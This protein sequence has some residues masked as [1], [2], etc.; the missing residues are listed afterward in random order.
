MTRLGM[1]G[2]RPR[3]PGFAARHPLP[4]PPTPLL[5]RE[6]ELIEV[7]VR[8]LRQDVRLLTLTGAGG[9]GKTRLAVE[10]ARML[11][12]RFIDGVF[13]VDLS[14][15]S[16]PAQV[17]PA[18][19]GVLGIRE[20][21]GQS[22]FDRLQ[23]VLAARE[24]L[25]LLDNFEH[26]L[27]AAPQIVEFVAAC[28]GLKILATSRAALRVRWEHEFVVWPL[29]V[30]EA[31]HA[32]DL[33]A[34]ARVPSVA[35][36]VERARA[37][38]PGLQLGRDNAP[39]IAEICQRLDGL[40]LALELAAARTRVLPPQALARRLDARLP[41]LS[42]GPRDVPARQQTL[43]ASIGW[44]YEL[45]NTPERRLFRRLAVFVG[46]G[47][48]DQVEQVC[49]DPGASDADVL[50]GLAGLLEHS[51]I[52]RETMP[53]GVARLRM[54]ETIR[55]FALD[56]LAASGEAED[57]RRRHALACVALAEAAD[58]DLFGARRMVFV[59]GLAAD[60]D[61][62]R[63]ALTWL[64]EHREAD[65]SCRLAGALTWW[66]YPLGR[67]RT[68]L[69]WAEQA[70]GCQA[71]GASPAQA[72]A[73]FAAGALALF[74]GDA[75]LARRRLDESQSLCEALSDDAGLAH[76]RLLLGIAI[77]AE[78]PAAARALQEH[79]L[80]VIRQ[81]GDPGW[82][83][84]AL[85]SCGDRAFAAGEVDPARA[86]FEESL[87][88]FQRLDDTMMA[89]Q[90]LNKLGDL[91]RSSDDYRRAA[92]LYTESLELLR[93]HGGET[94]IPGL[95]HNL[96]YVAQHHASQGQ[97]LGH[98]SEAMA[99]FRT[100]GDQRGIAECLAGVAGVAVALEQPER[101]ARLLGAADA[102]LR[103]AGAQITPA[104]VG[105]YRRGLAAAQARLGPAPF[106]TAW[107]RGQAMLS[108]QAI[109]YAVATADDLR[110]VADRQDRHRA[111][112]S[113]LTTRERE[114]ATLLGR[115]ATN[116]QIATELVISEQT[117][118]THVKHVLSKLGLASR[119]QVQDWLE[120]YGRVG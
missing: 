77:S 84:L 88:L 9:S 108:E 10:A 62:L 91:A 22:V 105:D 58:A 36:F 27:A 37:V 81:V 11:A 79:A 56:E 100:G 39:A 75:L 19:A 64:V 109:A 83:A 29:A 15:L 21:G 20:G 5:G 73:L 31:A 18:V 54:L 32:A 38:C 34:L 49:R 17:I 87:G 102:V 6:R 85:L 13:F 74:L 98:F 26:L 113:L 50:D 12:D 23:Q 53:D 3:A 41:T 80:A 55:E 95:L 104:N 82:I 28:P 115:G 94:G 71:G 51:L 4:A 76:A 14:S 45:L 59:N 101:A 110:A 119:H 48:L 43:R 65:L 30:P 96:G 117:A 2:R 78:N 63:T 120:R 57:I 16:D 89:A 1:A 52:R 35:L 116:R 72:K 92:T 8:L 86:L 99:L 44:S 103:A 93:Q 7:Q 68:G 70:L 114:V 106:M 42:N 25:L 111:R 97:A 107:S 60:Y 67:V 40:P 46:G 61:N 24:H 47:C 69:E 112:P 33:E 90:A 66:W 118:E